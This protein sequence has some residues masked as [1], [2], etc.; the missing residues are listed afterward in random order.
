MTSFGINS[1]SRVRDSSTWAG[2]IN[3]QFSSPTPQTTSFLQA[4]TLEVHFYVN[5]GLS[6]RLWIFFQLDLM[7]TA[8][9]Y[10]KQSK[11]VVHS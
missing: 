3:F 8:F 6:F 9:F 4:V 2:E 1:R 10:T 11:R 7:G 5:L